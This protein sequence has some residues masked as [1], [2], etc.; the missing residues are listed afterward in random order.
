M[1][2]IQSFF[3]VDDDDLTYDPDDD[4]T[5]SIGSVLFDN[6][7]QAADIDD[8]AVHYYSA[9]DSEEDSIASDD[10]KNIAVKEQDWIGGDL[11]QFPAS[12]NDEE[13][14]ALVEPDWIGGD[15]MQCPVADESTDE[16]SE[17]YE[18]MQTGAANAERAAA[19]LS[20]VWDKERSSVVSL[21]RD[22]IH[23]HEPMTQVRKKAAITA[24]SI[25]ADKVQGLIATMKKPLKSLNAAA[26]ED[27]KLRLAETFWRGALKHTYPADR[28]WF[29]ARGRS[30]IEYDKD[31]K[32]T[33]FKMCLGL[34]DVWEFQLSGD[35]I[36][37]N[38][39]RYKQQLRIEAGNM[40]DDV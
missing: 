17:H 39:Q 5:G 15:W 19:D 23:P 25:T 24:L 7:M 20:N 8:S 35:A 1:A 2:S 10:E 22:T 21:L 32:K 9:V 27:L 30:I 33:G 26:P 14:S 37:F 18:N 16:D 31:G 40:S 11:I 29:M 6:E 38:E 36:L 12:S 3:D 34:I 4:S 13:R 28:G